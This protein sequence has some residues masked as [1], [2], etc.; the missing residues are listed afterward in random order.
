MPPSALGVLL[1]QPVCNPMLF[2]LR[3]PNAADRELVSHCGVLEFTAVEDKIYIP[4]WKMKRMDLKDG[5]VVQVKN[6]SLPKGKFVKLQPHT[7]DFLDI[8]NPKAVLEKTLRN[9][10]CFTVGDTIMLPY[11]GKEY[12]VN[13]VETKPRKAIS[14]IETDCEVDFLPPL[15]YVEPEKPVAVASPPTNKAAMAEPVQIEEPKFCPFSGDGRRLDGKPLPTP[16]V[17][18]SSSSF[19]AAANNG[20]TNAQPSS[21]GSSSQGSNRHTQGKL[22]FGSNAADH[23]TTAPKKIEKQEASKEQAKQKKKE[24]SKFQP[25]TGK[26]YSLKG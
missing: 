5:D 21:T 7:K 17:Q 15:D 25:F 9:F 12:Y 6:V 1:S 11:N 22:V 16:Q 19:V 18:V 14:I 4:S 20:K 2:Q 3:N 8:T 24:D 10:T 23:T 13:I 26:I